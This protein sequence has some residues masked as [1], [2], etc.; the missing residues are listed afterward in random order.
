M[1]AEIR[2]AAIVRYAD[3]KQL[4]ENSRSAARSSLIRLRSDKG[5]ACLATVLDA[6][7][8]NRS[9]SSCAAS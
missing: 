6:A 8:A 2:P 3:M 1:S 9:L 4:R 5:Q 7:L